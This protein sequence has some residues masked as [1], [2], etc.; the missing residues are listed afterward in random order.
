VEQFVIRRVLADHE[1]RI[2]TALSVGVV[3]LCAFWKSA[4]KRMLRPQTMQEHS[5]TKA[6]TP[7]PTFHLHKPHV[8][9]LTATPGWWC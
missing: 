7:A 4:T 3:H 1:G 9:A 6:I 5:L 2:I 8:V